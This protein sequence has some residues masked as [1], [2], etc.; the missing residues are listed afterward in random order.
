MGRREWNPSLPRQATLAILSFAL[1][2][3]VPE[4]VP[5]LKDYKIFDWHSAPAVLDFAPRRVSV[6]PIEEEQ[7][8]LRPDA[9][10]NAYGLR[11][12]DEAGGAMDRFYAALVRSEA[13]EA[14]AEVNILHYG[15]SPTT[16]D[17]ITA[18]A[19][20][21]LQKQFGDGGHG[22]CLIAKPWAW[23]EHRGVSLSGGHWITEP[24]NQSQNRDGLFGLG[25][26]SFRG[27]EDAWSRVVLRETG[28]TSVEVA[29]LK[30]PGGGAF[31]L[32]IG[33]RRVRVDTAAPE[34]G[35]GYARFEAP[36]QERRFEIHVLRG[37]VR[38]FGYRFEKPAP[39]LVYHSLGVNGAYVAVP[40]RMFRE[41]HWAG[42]LRHY[43]P[44]LVV[45]NYGTNESVYPNFVD[46]GFALELKEVVRRVR[47]A[48]PESSIL[49]MSPMD[50]G[51]RESTGE[52]GTV[53]ALPRVVAIEQRVAR[54]SGCAFF[55][56]FQAM[57]GSGTMGRWYQA[58]PRL[59][60]ADFIHPMPAGA[61]IVG[62]LLAKALV[63]GYNKYKLERM[64]PRLAQWD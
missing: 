4:F 16:A 32:K 12:L 3:A 24:A 54:E 9:D 56:T 62:N 46:S 37:P 60:S 6:S 53:P 28:H 59:V 33:E 42:Q 2:V 23:Y 36:P 45:I 21:A 44:S 11:P 30:M 1:M 22:F 61:R 8:R 39:G 29:F 34:A 48:V 58:E 52:I 14:G 55:N 20:V 27:E 38:L 51:K 13:R 17:L 64:R 41:E 10:P 5:A 35:P 26:V 57:G 50:R 18:D 25:G 40:S 49:V 43:A 47:A 7:R 63:D 15:D 31:E 19:R